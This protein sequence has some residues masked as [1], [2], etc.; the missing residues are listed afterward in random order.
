MKEF[1]N[2]RS[3]DGTG[4]ISVYDKY[5]KPFEECPDC[6]GHGA[7]AIDGTKF[8]VLPLFDKVKH[9]RKI[10]NNKEVIYH[11]YYLNG[12]LQKIITDDQY[13][14]LVQEIL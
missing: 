5:T 4:V 12:K 9:F 14:Q 10:E 6:E 3:C 2:C 11:A 8:S 1:I 7:F 13:C